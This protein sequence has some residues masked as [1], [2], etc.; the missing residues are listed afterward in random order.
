[1]SHHFVVYMAAKRAGI[2]SHRGLYVL[3]GDDIVIA[4]DDLAREYKYIIA[5]LGVELSESKTHQSDTMFEFAKRWYH[6]GGE[7]HSPF[8]INAVQS[9]SKYTDVVAIII[10]AEEKG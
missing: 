9:K 10:K 8:P 4:N 1:M 7:E 6:V 3:L 5:R 2:R